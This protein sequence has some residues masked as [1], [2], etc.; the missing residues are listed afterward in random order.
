MSPLLIECPNL[1]IV[2]LANPEHAQECGFYLQYIV[3]HY[4]KLSDYSIFVH[5]DPQN[6]NPHLLQQLHWLIPLSRDTLKNIDFLHLN[7]QEYVERY[8]SNAGTF[9]GLLGFNSQAFTSDGNI[10]SQQIQSGMRYFASECCAQF[11]VSS[12]AIRTYPLEFWQLALKLTLDNKSFCI[13]WE[14]IWHAVFL[15]VQKLPVNLTLDRLYQKNNP[16]FSSRCLNGRR[17]DIV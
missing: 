10:T 9:L 1:R 14:Y 15:N 2:P 6:H 3:D 4:D 8:S 17:S 13:V 7:C 12:K 11:I 5:G 16:S